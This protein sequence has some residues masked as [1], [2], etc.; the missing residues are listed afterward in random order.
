MS[1]PTSDLNFE[2]QLSHTNVNGNANAI[3]GTDGIAQLKAPDFSIQSG[4]DREL[5]DEELELGDKYIEDIV[6]DDGSPDE[7]DE[8]FGKGFASRF[9]YQ[10]SMFEAIWSDLGK[11]D[12]AASDKGMAQ[13]DYQTGGEI[14]DALIG[15]MISALTGPEEDIDYHVMEGKLL[16]EEL[17]IST[18][19]LNA[20]V[21][22]FKAVE[23]KKIIP[24]LLLFA[25]MYAKMDFY[26]FQS[27]LHKLKKDTEKLRKLVDDAYKA[28]AAAGVETAIDIGSILL[29]ASI[30]G[31]IGVAN[32]V[33]GGIIMLGL[34]YGAKKASNAII[35]PP[36]GPDEPTGSY[37]ITKSDEGLDLLAKG[38]ESADTAS[39]QFK[40]AIG[41]MGTFKAGVT[42]LMGVA[43][44][45]KAA[46]TVQELE[47]Y[48]KEYEK[49]NKQLISE[50]TKEY[51]EKVKKTGS[52]AKNLYNAGLEIGPTI[53]DALLEIDF[54]GN[55]LDHFRDEY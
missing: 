54:Y 47:A 49:V 22:L 3:S 21:T 14:M 19:L 42:G 29:E 11:Y 26:E 34:V 46:L 35:K 13:A 32:P 51:D 33:A 41:K 8:L 45:T 44:T 16:I 23:S 37:L 2:N 48:Y 7:I 28:L 53:D 9:S 4:T 25:D 30:L 43:K 17:E 6:G 24:L 40:G 38:M 50:I 18:D 39:D 27:K 20:Y 31:A 5:T 36:A 15:E 12:L 52:A 10:S 55:E 1:T